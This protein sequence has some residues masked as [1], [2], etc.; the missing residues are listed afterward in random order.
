MRKPAAEGF[1]VKIIHN[2]EEFVVALPGNVDFPNSP[3][4]IY[5]SLL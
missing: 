2:D 5:D 4:F 3:D 1:L